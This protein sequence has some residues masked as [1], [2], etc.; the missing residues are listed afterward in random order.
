[1]LY[2]AMGAAITAAAI[3]EYHRPDTVLSVGV[4]TD[5]LGLWG[6]D[7]I[8]SFWTYMLFTVC[9]TTLTT[10]PSRISS[11]MLRR[12]VHSLPL[13]ADFLPLPELVGHDVHVPAV[14][15]SNG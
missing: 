13:R 8:S 15:K 3:Y 11:R 4:L 2:A 1:M 12:N 10:Y 6:R 7:M 9:W 14:F 5:L